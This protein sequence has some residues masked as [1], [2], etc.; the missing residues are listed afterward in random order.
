MTS[1]MIRLSGHSRRL[2]YFAILF[3]IEAS[4]ARAGSLIINGGFEMP[5][6]PKDKFTTLQAGSTALTGW[7]ILF[8]SVDV[9]N[10]GYWPSFDGDQSLDLDGNAP[11]GIQQTFDT[12]DLTDYTLIFWYANNPDMPNKLASARYD[13]FGSEPLGGLSF[14]HVGST[15]AKMNYTMTLDD[16]VADSDRTTIRFSSLDQTDS[17]FGI[18]L[19]A[20]TIVP[21][22]SLVPEPTSLTLLTL[23]IVALCAFKVRNCP[24][25]QGG[26]SS[27]HAPDHRQIHC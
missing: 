15:R 20:V 14:T 1:I 24:S 13:I 7:T 5:V 22:S 9:V 26:A 19:D 4:S 12:K 8:G 17:K 2:G 18:V 25:P 27:R 16:F 10:K 3:I 6:V 21:S 23:G 11:G